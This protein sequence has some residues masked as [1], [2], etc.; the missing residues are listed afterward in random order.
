ML[1]E[2]LIGEVTEDESKTAVKPA[3]A[4]PQYSLS[5]YILILYVEVS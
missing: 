3:I 4:K 2:Y 5:M 1:K